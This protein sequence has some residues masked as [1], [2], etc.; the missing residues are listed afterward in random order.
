MPSVQYAKCVMLPP[1]NPRNKLVLYLTI[2]STCTFQLNKCSWPWKKKIIF[3]KKPLYIREKGD[4]CKAGRVKQPKHLS[5]FY[6]LFFLYYP[7]RKDLA[8]KQP[9]PLN[10]AC[11]FPCCGVW[12]STAHICTHIPI[13]GGGGEVHT[14]PLHPPT[15]K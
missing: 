1:S 10:I 3:I 14:R 15:L 13:L 5:L 6:L 4:L 9:P 7:L 11:Y 2:Y 8:Q 12:Q